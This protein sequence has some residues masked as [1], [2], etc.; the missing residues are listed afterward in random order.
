MRIIPYVFSSETEYLNA[1]I[2]PLIEETHADVLAS[3]TSLSDPSCLEIESIK[4]SR[5]YN[6]PKDLLYELDLKRGVSD[7]RDA[8]VYEPEPGDLIAISSV[9][10]KCVSDLDRPERAYVNA[11]VKKV[12]EENERYELLILSSKP[13][14]ADDDTEEG[15]V[16][17]LFAVK[18]ANLTTNIRIWNSLHS[19]SELANRRI[20]HNVLL[21]DFLV[22]IFSVL[23][24]R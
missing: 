4:T 1:F 18:L 16:G 7:Q 13:I 14:I 24:H 9:R 22:R 15:S 11:Y 5:D 23:S 19:D 2:A 12:K 10:P 8:P 6:L 3:F 21:T 20:I 17:A